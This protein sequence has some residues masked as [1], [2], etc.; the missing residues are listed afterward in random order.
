M[1]L[2]VE[3]GKPAPLDA[4]AAAARV[5]K[6]GLLHHFPSQNEL[7]VAMCMDSAERIRDSVLSLVDPKDLQPGRLLRAYVRALLGESPE[8]AAALM[9]FTALTVFKDVPGAQTTI[10]DDAQY[11]RDAFTDDGIEPGVWLAV[12]FAAEGVVP[13]L[14]TPYLTNTE[15]NLLQQHLL[16]LTEPIN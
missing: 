7:A 3:N 6:G 10:E 15:H 2:L 11:W 9:H 12:R 4:I 8:A 1:T 13:C 16:A 14:G 5:S